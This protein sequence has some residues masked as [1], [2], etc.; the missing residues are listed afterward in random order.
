MTQSITKSTVKIPPLEN[1]DRLTRLEFET[2][3]QKMTHV[4]KAELIE[5]IVY[6]GS[7][8]RINKHGEPHA[9]IM[10]W[11]TVYKA[12]TPNV[13]TGDNATVRLDP[14]NEPQPDALLRIEKGG[15][16]IISEDGYVEGAPE[17]IVEIAASTVSI[18]LHDKLKAYRRNQVQEYVVWRVDDNE[19]DWFRL[20]DEK[21][22]K[23]QADENGIIKSEIY[24]GLWL[25]VTALLKGDLVKVLDVLKQGI[26]TPAH[27]N[28]CQKIS[29][30]D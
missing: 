1:G 21:Y 14:E 26:D 12:F 27:T 18:D 16:S 4:K 6:M 2:R 10:G 25:D 22:I 19:I 30:N 28:F 13:Q 8:L 5:G 24:P 17:L 9:D 15:Q 29:I 7:P 20:K 3:Y 11:L 23:L